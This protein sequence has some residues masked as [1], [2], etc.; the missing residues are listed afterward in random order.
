MTAAHAFAGPYE[1]AFPAPAAHAPS[2][3]VA[4]RLDSARRA[5]EG[6]FLEA[7]DVL[8]KAVD[9]LSKLV[10]SLDKLGATL[11][12]ETVAATTAELGAAAT[13]LMA[14]PARHV[15]RRE[16]MERMAALG[17]HLAGGIEDMRRNLSYLRVFAINIKITAGGIS[18][19]D[20]EFGAFAQEI[21]DC[22]EDG[23]DQLD[24][25]DTELQALSGVFR[26]SVAHEVA[27]AGQCG[28]LLPAVPDGLTASAA[29][30]ADH[31]RRIAQ[32]ALDVAQVAR[33]V[34]KKVG[35]ALGALQIGDITR[36][37]IEHVGEALALL[38]AAPDVSADQR[39]R[40][41]AFI[42]DLLAAQLR[43]TA[44]DFHRDVAR[45]GS[46]MDGIA[47]DAGEILRLRDLAFGRG[48]GGGQGF[49]RALEG[50]VGQAL[51]LVEDMSRADQEALKVGGAAVTAAAGLGE[52]IAGLRE[53][54]TDVQHMALN[55]ALK[56]SRI[57][58][59]GKPLAVIAIELRAHAGYMDISAQEAMS[60][61]DTLSNDAAL[62]S[63]AGADEAVGNAGGV[64]AVLSDVTERLRTA[65]DAVEAD[66][67]SL[68]RQGD[69]MVGALH[70]M[71][72]RMDLER[73]IGAILDDAAD[74]LAEG[75]GG[76]EG[77]GLGGPLG[78]LLALIAK[79]YTMVQER[80]VHQAFADSLPFELTAAE[81]PTQAAVEADPDDVLF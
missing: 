41:S 43:A 70:Q 6:R 34:Q 75:A 47:T 24:A 81:P 53:I 59:A 16:A 32:A 33:R 23:R 78:E 25:F 30:M 71:A 8:G 4:L 31:H 21:R 73:E 79:R 46:A 10:A 44:G 42:H 49:L 9:G 26:E 60:A 19:A 12:A 20:K 58:D 77:E 36:Q 72:G 65:G 55:T 39:E 15:E 68:A 3:S 22:I 7:G 64:G 18:A 66:L 51:A 11:D 61:V 17:A 50:H 28:A 76:G 45:I 5:V 14:L 67:A 1:D 2:A 74:A 63:A 35:Q 56:C 54:K 62:L 69:A 52:R 48:D 40:M 37:R 29:A 57:G 27:L 38:E 80:E 13:E